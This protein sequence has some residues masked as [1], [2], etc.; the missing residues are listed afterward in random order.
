MAVASAHDPRARQILLEYA[1]K[2][3]GGNFRTDALQAAILGRDFR[4]ST[5]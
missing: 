1:H 2:I 3:V 5:L 4:T